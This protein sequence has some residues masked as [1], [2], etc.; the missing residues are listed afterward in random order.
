MKAFA[1]AACLLFASFPALA[2]G[3]GAPATHDWCGV[4]AGLHLGGSWGSSAWTDLNFGGI[5]SHQASGG[6]GGLQVG[7]DSQS[8]EWVWGGRADLSWAGIEGTHQDVVFTDGAAPQTDRGKIDILGTLTARLGH[9]WGPVL[10]SVRGGAA[11]AHA[12]YSLEGYF[13]P[14][15]QFSATGATRWGWTAGLGLEYGFA[16]PWAAFL[17]YDYVALGT[18]RV[19]LACTTSSAC[20]LPG[21][22][23]VPLDVRENFNVAKVGVGY[24][25]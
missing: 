20:A 24:R 3:S 10:V 13:A 16:G 4:S 17:E 8:G 1:A 25:F 2:Q 19:D 5:G 6:L 9:A 14:G 18:K 22:G 15:L 12:R 21:N 11:W 23:P 7:F